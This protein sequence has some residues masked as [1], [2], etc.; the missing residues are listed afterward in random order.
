MM[1]ITVTVII[2]IWSRNALKFSKLYKLLNHRS[3][4]LL[5]GYVFGNLF[6]TLMSYEVIIIFS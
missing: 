3:L 1:A 6:F 5:Y 2:P 4:N